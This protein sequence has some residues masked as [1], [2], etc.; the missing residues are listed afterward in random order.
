MKN[1]A[2]KSGTPANPA[3]QPAPAA[4]QR[5]TH[6][7]IHVET[8]VCE[9]TADPAVRLKLQPAAEGEVVLSIAQARALSLALITAVNR[10]ERHGREHA[11]Q[12]RLTVAPQP[13][14]R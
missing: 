5:D 14:E 9:R 6:P 2:E 10:Q 13:A 4:R 3:Q 1:A 11:R 8:A 7:P 12:V